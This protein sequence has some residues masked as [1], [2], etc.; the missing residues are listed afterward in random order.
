MIE[1]DGHL[2]YSPYPPHQYGKGPLGHGPFCQG[3]L[4]QWNLIWISCPAVDQYVQPKAKAWDIA[5]A[6]PGHFLADSIAA[7]RGKNCLRL[8]PKL[9]ESLMLPPLQFIQEVQTMKYQ[10]MPMYLSDPMWLHT[11]QVR[12]VQ[13]SGDTALASWEATHKLLDGIMRGGNTTRPKPGG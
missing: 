11:I 4:Q 10:H 5:R 12:A 13:A 3:D 2:C 8:F 7:L 1:I 9:R 6:I